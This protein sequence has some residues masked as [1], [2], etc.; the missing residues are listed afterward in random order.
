MATRRST[1]ARPQRDHPLPFE[2]DRA[3][4]QAT[5]DAK[6]RLGRLVAGGT[7]GNEQLTAA[8]GLVLMV[9]LA[10]LGVTIVRIGPLL[11]AHMFIGLLLVPPILLKIASTGYRFV[12]YYTRSPSYRR[13]G[14]PAA[15]MR[16][17][18]PVVVLSTV[19]VFAS[20]VALLLVGPSSRGALLPIHKASFV[21]W[22]ASTAIHV[23]GHLPELPRAL[24][25]T[26]ES[27]GEWS[28]DGTGRAG[29]LLSLAGAVVA[30]TVLAILYIPQF[31]P[32]LHAHDFLGAH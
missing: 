2:S 8:A 27:R 1:P 7:A 16:A 23:I 26:S 31:T 6:S 3:H 13:E 32:W 9:L 15:S 4:G 17:I 14:P 29:R 24:R 12:R 25:A 20:G 19:V 30:G 28:G 10:A 5:G 21:V 22:I 18:A 11:A